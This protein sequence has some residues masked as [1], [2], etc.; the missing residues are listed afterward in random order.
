MSF[1]VFVFLDFIF[2]KGDI[3]LSYKQFLIDINGFVCRSLRLNCCYVILIFTLTRTLNRIRVKNPVGNIGIFYTKRAFY[4]NKSFK[5]TVYSRFLEFK[6]RLAHQRD[7]RKTVSFFCQSILAKT[8][9]SP[10]FSIDA[11]KQGLFVYCKQ[12]AFYLE[13]EL[14]NAIC[15]KH[16]KRRCK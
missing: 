12:A 5:N 7:S 6:S 11:E 16:R 2:G 13:L 14:R 1:G 4:A 9:K 10:V 8:V 3:L 15:K